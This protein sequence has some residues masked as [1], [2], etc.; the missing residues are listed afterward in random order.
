MIYPQAFI[1]YLVHFHGDRDFF[2]CHEILEDYWKDHKM[3][4]EIWVALIQ[5]AVGLY[6]QRRGNHAGAIKML[7]SSLQKMEQKKITQLG[8]NYE[9]MT[10]LIK[11]RMAEIAQGCVYTDIDLPIEDQQL[12]V[13]CLETCKKKNL[14]WGSTSMDNRDLVDRHKLRDRS[15]VIKQREERLLQKLN[16]RNQDSYTR[17]QE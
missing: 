3:K 6:H 9:K 14:T 5:L 15:D 1:D 12:H 2:E 10:D 8:L 16:H 13:Q 7:K 11:R 17:L 4:E